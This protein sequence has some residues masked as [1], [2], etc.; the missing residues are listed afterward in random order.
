MC[1]WWWGFSVSVSFSCY[2]LYALAMAMWLSWP[3]TNLTCKQ[4]VCKMSRV[5]VVTLCRGDISR[6]NLTV[7]VLYWESAC[8]CTILYYYTRHLIKTRYLHDVRCTL[9][10]YDTAYLNPPYTAIPEFEEWTKELPQ[11]A[12]ENPSQGERAEG[13]CI[14]EAVRDVEKKSQNMVSNVACSL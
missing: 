4:E 2:G 8:T 11:W 7:F 13:D 10:C 3:V 9:S 14:E 5:V 12:R 1:K 6:L